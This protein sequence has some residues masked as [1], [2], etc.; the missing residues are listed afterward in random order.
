MCEFKK[1]TEGQRDSA[2]DGALD[3]SMSQH[4][5]MILKGDPLF[6]SLASMTTTPDRASDPVGSTVMNHVS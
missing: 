3:E 5:K 6:P 2:K 1:H 4:L